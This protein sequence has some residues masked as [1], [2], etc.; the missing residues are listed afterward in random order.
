MKKLKKPL[1]LVLAL[2][3]VCSLAMFL[4][5]S[6][7]GEGTFSITPS[8]TSVKVGETVTFAV[9]MG[10]EN[11]A[12]SS[13]KFDVTF[14]PAYYELVNATDAAWD[15]AMPLITAGTVN[16][17]VSDVDGY[18]GNTTVTPIQSIDTAA[19]ATGTV[20]FTAIN[21]D[22]SITANNVAIAT[23]TLKAKAANDTATVTVTPDAT[24][25]FYV[26]QANG[27]VN[28][29]PIPYLTANTT[30]VLEAN[31]A[32]NAYGDANGDDMI[33]AG[34]VTKIINALAVATAYKKNQSNPDFY[35]MDSAKG[36]TVYFYLDASGKVYA[37]NNADKSPTTGVVYGDAN[38]D[39]MITA[40]DV[41]KVIN[42]LAVATAYKKNQTSPN[43]YTMDNS[44]GLTV[45]F[46]IEGSKVMV[47]NSQ[48]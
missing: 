43:S 39:N 8:N 33:T 18:I 27:T 14:D 48:S 2:A 5:A 7:A 32:A 31:A 41:T 16:G 37:T 29:T 15:D 34:D 38:G 11:N 1:S 17:S 30:V 6:A 21:V 13:V 20:T 22:A 9:K 19:A 44:K 28:E 10:A 47:S 42:A 40:G 23:I 36:I 26:D 3:M 25:F 45:Y 4:P 46:R 12:V 24:S 35:V